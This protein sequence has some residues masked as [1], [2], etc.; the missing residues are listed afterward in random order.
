MPTNHEN[1]V[2]ST[3]SDHH[4]ENKGCVAIHIGKFDLKQELQFQK[5]CKTKTKNDLPQN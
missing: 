4:L 5:Y 1:D 3:A 2:L